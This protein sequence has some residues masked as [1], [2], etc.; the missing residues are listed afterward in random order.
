MPYAKTRREAIEARQG[1]EF[2]AKWA[3]R[4]L[5]A[6]ALPLVACAILARCA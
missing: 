2:V 3:C 5:L 4:F 6:G 1:R